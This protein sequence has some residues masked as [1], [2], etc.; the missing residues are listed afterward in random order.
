MLLGTIHLIYDRFGQYNGKSDNM[1][2]FDGFGCGCD[3]CSVE[4]DICDAD[5]SSVVGSSVRRVDGYRDERR[6]GQ[7]YVVEEVLG[8]IHVLVELMHW[9]ER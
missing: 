9:S 6:I 1:E 2:M 3:E 5:L 7:G 8:L 4:C